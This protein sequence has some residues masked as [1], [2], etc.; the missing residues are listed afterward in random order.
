MKSGELDIFRALTAVPTAPF[1]E[2]AVGR[3]A[4]SWIRSHLGRRVQVRRLRGGF[5]VTYRG[6]GPG[7]ALAL[8]AHLDHP[9]FHLQ[10][11]TRRGARAVLKGG[12]PREL[13]P[14]CLVE[15]FAAKPKDNR[16][17]ALG[18]L[19]P[20][21]R[22]GDA[23]KLSWTSPPRPGARLAFGV[24]SLTPCAIEDGWVCSRSIDDLLGCAIALETLRRTAVARVKTNLK[25]FLH[26]AEEVGFVGAL[27]FARRGGADPQDSVLSIEASRSLPGARP[28]KGPVIRLGDKA[29]LFDPNLVALLDE[30]ASG[31]S[32]RGIPVQRRRLTGGT[33]E[34]TAYQAFGY[35]AAGVALPLVNYH[36]GIGAREV[37]PEKV[38]GRDA[39]GCVELLLAAARLF[40]AA[41]LR[42]HWRRRLERRQRRS[43]RF[44]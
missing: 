25:V 14:G 9:G 42:G 16:P 5:I 39:A 6:A 23:F 34:A 22:R 2:E 18:R 31:L 20:Q 35:E 15:A 27:D 12:H 30:A 8:A 36:N 7:P 17:A 26:R 24:L 43:E 10:A 28:G 44:L 37:A 32:K 1:F 3:R 40:P 11:V 13:L 29:A 38:R 41:P 21:P 19:G 33:C 4:L